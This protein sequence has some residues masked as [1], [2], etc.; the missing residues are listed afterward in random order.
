MLAIQSDYCTAP[1]SAQR[2]HWAAA[3]API[4]IV[5]R[6]RSQLFFL[7][8]RFMRSSRGA[9][10]Q[11]RKQRRFVAD[12]PRP[13]NK[14]VSRIPIRMEG[15]GLHASIEGIITIRLG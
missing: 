5:K 8:I 10:S 7:S 3:R 12:A 4:L 2:Q 13:I 9:H 15:G 14:A 11:S 6:S 1:C